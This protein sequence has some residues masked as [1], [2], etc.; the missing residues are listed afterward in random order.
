MLVALPF[1]LSAAQAAAAPAPSGHMQ[2]FIAPSGE[3]FRVGGNAP[4][5]VAQW[6]AGADKNGDGKL[7]KDEFV[8][9]FL[10]FFDQLDVDHDGAIDGVERLR[11]ENEIAPETLGGSSEQRNAFADEPEDSDIAGEGAAADTDAP[12]PR[13]GANPIG[14]GRFD[15]FGMPEPVAAMDT[16]L[17]GRITRRVA[18]QAAEDRFAMLDQLHRGYLTLDS[19]P[20]TYAQRGGHVGS[21][22]DRR[23]HS[24]HGGHGGGYGRHQG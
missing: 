17:R 10:R 1:L 23:G 15:L 22:P 2:I 9:D 11:Y 14:A 16:E 20:P 24:G 7:D 19:L 5:P 3:P 6:F 4:Y 12:K 13:Y 8:A 21:G 18:Q